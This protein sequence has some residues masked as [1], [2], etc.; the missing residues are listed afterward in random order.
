M[1]N[2][3]KKGFWFEIYS[4]LSL[5]VIRQY[6]PIFHNFFP[7]RSSQIRYPLL[8]KWVKLKTRSQDSLRIT[9]FKLHS[10]IYL[11]LKSHFAER[12][13]VEVNILEIKTKL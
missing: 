7:T 6:K 10:K 3:G 4:F 8:E 11:N 13:I 2:Y 9:P 12:A 5:S 1:T